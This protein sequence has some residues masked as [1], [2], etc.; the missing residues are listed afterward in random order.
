MDFPS[1][2]TVGG[3]IDIASIAERQRERVYKWFNARIAIYDDDRIVTTPYDPTTDAGGETT[4]TLLYDSG[5]NGARVQ[6]LNTRRN[7]TT[8]AQPTGERTFLVQTKL[9]LDI[10]VIRHGLRLLVLDGGEDSS[11]RNYRYFVQSA[12]NSSYAWNRSIICTALM[13]NT[14]IGA[15]SLGL[16]PGEDVEP[17]NDLEPEPTNG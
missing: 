2:P 1:F 9:D 4:A 16:L 14:D 7:L 11:L 17:S 10:D 12:A 13:T 15:A 6:P 3:Q 5:V 8:G